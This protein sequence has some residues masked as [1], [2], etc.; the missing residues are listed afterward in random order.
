MNTQPAE[1][2]KTI[3]AIFSD[4]L[5]KPIMPPAHPRRTPEGR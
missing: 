4:Y 3:N 2:P 5:T 1:M